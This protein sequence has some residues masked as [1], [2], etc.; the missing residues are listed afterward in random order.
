MGKNSTK[1]TAEKAL[2]TVKQDCG[3]ITMSKK[4]GYTAGPTLKEGE[5]YEVL[6]FDGDNGYVA[7]VIDTD[8][9]VWIDSDKV[10]IP[11]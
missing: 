1:V 7:L 11:D 9:H 3:T 8:T 10:E 2:A 5:K 6:P 4:N